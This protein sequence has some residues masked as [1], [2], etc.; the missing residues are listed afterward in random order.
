MLVKGGRGEQGGQ[1]R[2]IESGEGRETL[3]DP[4]H[5]RGN[6]LDA[7]M[8]ANREGAKE[9]EKGRGEKRGK[10]DRRNQNES[11]WKTGR[12]CKREIE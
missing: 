10:A 12:E 8:R 4:R 7:G 2:S 5:P 11:E 6:E 3:E 1:E 9:G